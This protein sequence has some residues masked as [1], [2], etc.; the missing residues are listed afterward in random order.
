[1]QERLIEVWPGVSY[2][3]AVRPQQRLHQR[4]DPVRRVFTRQLAHTPGKLVL[5]R[6]R[7]PPVLD[8]GLLEHPHNR[9]AGFPRER[10]RWQLRYHL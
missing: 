4:L 10:A 1:M 3:A 9:A 5:R 7:R 8:T 2:E 6:G